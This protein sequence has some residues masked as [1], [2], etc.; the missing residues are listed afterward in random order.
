MIKNF[1][2]LLADK[3]R[4]ESDRPAT[5]P[6]VARQR[7]ATSTPSSEP[8]GIARPSEISEAAL[9]EPQTLR[10][11]AR[12]G[13]QVDGILWEDHEFS[14]SQGNSL[15]PRFSANL[16]SHTSIAN[17]W[18]L[19]A[20]TKHVKDETIESEF[21]DELPEETTP[22]DRLLPA[23][24][25]RA[26]T[27]IIA[28]TEA[29]GVSLVKL[30][31]L[32]ASLRQWCLNPIPSD[33]DLLSVPE[34]LLEDDTPLPSDVGGDLPELLSGPAFRVGARNEDWG[35]WHAG[36]LSALTC[37]TP[38]GLG[39]S[40]DGVDALLTK[41]SSMRHDPVELPASLVAWNTIR[42]ESVQEEEG[43]SEFVQKFSNRLESYRGG[44]ASGGRRGRRGRLIGRLRRRRRGD[45]EAGLEVEP[46]E[47][48]DAAPPFPE[49]GRDTAGETLLAQLTGAFGPA[50]VLVGG[51]GGGAIPA[52]EASVAWRD[53]SLDRSFRS[54]A[55]TTAKIVRGEEQSAQVKILLGI[56]V[57]LYRNSLLISEE[58]LEVLPESVQGLL[59]NF[60]AK[61]D[62]PNSVMGDAAF[63]GVD[64][65][66]RGVPTLSVDEES[67]DVWAGERAS[68][69]LSEVILGGKFDS[70]AMEEWLTRA[71]DV[72]K[73]N[74][75]VASAVRWAGDARDVVAPFCEASQQH[76][77]NLAVGAALLQNYEEYKRR[78]D[79][80]KRDAAQAVI[81]GDRAIRLNQRRNEALIKPVDVAQQEFDTALNRARFLVGSCKVLWVNLLRATGQSTNQAFGNQ[82]WEV[83]DNSLGSRSTEQNY[84][85][86]LVQIKRTCEFFSSDYIGR[87]RDMVTVVELSDDESTPLWENRS[88]TS[89]NSS[90]AV[91]VGTT[92]RTSDQ[93]PPTYY[94]FW[95]G[96]QIDGE[97]TKSSKWTIAQMLDPI[98]SGNINRSGAD[99]VIAFQRRNLTPFASVFAS[100]ATA[101]KR[102]EAARQELV[103]ALELKRST[104]DRLTEEREALLVQQEEAINEKIGSILAEA[105][106]ESRRRTT[107]TSILAQ[108]ILDRIHS[109]A[110]LLSA[111]ALCTWN[112]WAAAEQWLTEDAVP[113]TQIAAKKCS[114]M[115]LARVPASD[116]PRQVEDAL[117]STAGLSV[118][119]EKVLWV[120]ES[121]PELW[122]EA[123]QVI[124]KDIVGPTFVTL[125]DSGVFVGAKEGDDVLIA[126]GAKLGCT[127]WKGYSQSTVWTA[128]LLASS[129]SINMV[130]QKT[131]EDWAI[132]DSLAQGQGAVPSIFA[133]QT[134]QRIGFLVD[135]GDFKHILDGHEVLPRVLWVDGWAVRENGFL[136]TVPLLYGAILERMRGI[137]SPLK[138]LFEEIEE[139]DGITADDV[140]EEFVDEPDAVKL[141]VVKAESGSLLIA[142]ERLRVMDELVQARLEAAQRDTDSLP[143][144]PEGQRSGAFGNAHLALL[145]S[146]LTDAGISIDLYSERP[147][148]VDRVVTSATERDASLWP[149]SAISFCTSTWNNTLTGWS[150]TSSLRFDD[151]L[152]AMPKWDKWN[153]LDTQGL[154][155]LVDDGSLTE[156]EALAEACWNFAVFSGNADEP[157]VEVLSY[158]GV[159][160]HYEALASVVDDNPSRTRAL[161]REVC[162]NELISQ[163]TGALVRTL[164][165]VEARERLWVRGS[166]PDDPQS[167]SGRI[168]AASMPRLQGRL[169]WIPWS[170]STVE[171]SLNSANVTDIDVARARIGNEVSS[172]AFAGELSVSWTPPLY[173][174]ASHW[175]DEP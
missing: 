51:A 167:A 1:G 35:S 162:R 142:Q 72:L 170:T 104:R 63:E 12:E 124:A 160:E 62:F 88:T 143:T 123:F 147:T 8:S 24:Y 34:P 151:G 163:C 102:L 17:L 135:A 81:S 155:S 44:S 149:R 99:A 3:G 153:W 38:A 84:A 49:E 36:L 157:N 110:Q 121:T 47:Q 52:E 78:V 26:E 105:D 138:E 61:N 166:L 66:V 53:G 5:L 54:A 126:E 46:E 64:G 73:L 69:W 95:N 76:L 139:N 113:L 90:S 27:S 41:I 175:R 16:S 93:R 172:L 70:G 154:L 22:F 18:D 68:T 96:N 6:V 59:Q 11:I 171:L 45:S 156:W 60:A 32:I 94:Q 136:R 15:A 140:D 107:K 165:G 112:E 37:S 118:D 134:N 87:Y 125:L 106:L 57:A 43:E 28:N 137:V 103:A 145:H 80:A 130:L 100:M 122:R 169:R 55:A 115:L 25:P 2:K 111:V 40:G 173:V 128:L 127:R 91:L 89:S 159:L 132:V 83:F 30:H 56:L 109:D 174:G 98:R 92:V 7:A 74:G 129:I 79:E 20:S 48:E 152:W 146:T 114:D 21:L 33:V 23:L 97:Y 131:K 144:T 119:E 164:W 133:S 168:Q 19:I 9:A 101:V 82:M 71:E 86:A 75:T 10:T 148:F 77:T 42:P 150:S 31:G 4:V 161:G 67:V 50:P 58:N 117:R 108:W 29:L 85:D 120:V 14:A 65:D 158:R 13:Q 116:N 141:A 39:K